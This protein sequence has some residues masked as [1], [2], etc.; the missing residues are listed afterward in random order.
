MSRMAL[1]LTCAF[2]LFSWL[3]LTYCAFSWLRVAKQLHYIRYYVPDTPDTEFILYTLYLLSCAFFRIIST[4][5]MTVFGIA[6]LPWLLILNYLVALFFFDLPPQGMD[7]YS[8]LTHK[9]ARDVSLPGGWIWK[10]R[11]SNVAVSSCKVINKSYEYIPVSLH[12]PSAI[13]IIRLYVQVTVL[14]GV[15]VYYYYYYLALSIRSTHASPNGTM[16]G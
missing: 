2:S 12:C 8:P 16:Y 15:L 3:F 4:K 5:R 14:T 7:G 9:V 10:K 11:A 1:K 13:P 6:Y